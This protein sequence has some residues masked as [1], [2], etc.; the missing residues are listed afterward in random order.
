MVYF[1][2]NGGAEDAVVAAINNAKTQILVEEY[3]LTS[4]P[5]VNA[6]VHASNNG[7]EV[8]LLYDKGDPNGTG[9][10][11]GLWRKMKKAEIW[12]QVDKPS[13]G[14]IAHNK[15]MIIDSNVTVTGS[16]NFTENAA[17]KN[18]ENLLIITDHTIAMKYLANWYVRA[19]EP[20]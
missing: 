7:V 4:K 18:A 17:H 2:P 6:L 3:R 20:D 10:K 14:G 5:I 13:T 9:S 19:G 11:K 8:D 15:I 12:I 1:N 16:F